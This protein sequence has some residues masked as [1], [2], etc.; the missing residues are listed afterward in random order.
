[1]SSARCPTCQTL[2]PPDTSFC[3]NCG[4]PLVS[5]RSPAPRPVVDELTDDAPRPVRVDV[6]FRVWTGVKLGAGF[7][8]GA[9]LVTLLIWMLIVAFVALGLSAT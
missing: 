8:I 5:G 3:P 7:V 1:M 2:R 6:D 4:T 9:T